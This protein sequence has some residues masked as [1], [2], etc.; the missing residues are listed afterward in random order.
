MKLQNKSGSLDII[1]DPVDQFWISRNSFYIDSKGKNLITS[2]VYHKRWELLTLIAGTYWDKKIKLSCANND[3]RRESISY[4]INHAKVNTKANRDGVF[5]SGIE[6]QDQFVAVC[7]E[8][9]RKPIKTVFSDF[10]SAV[11]CYS[12]YSLSLFYQILEVPKRVPRKLKKLKNKIRF[13]IDKSIV[14]L[15]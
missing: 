15:L 3:L 8:W 13:K 12:R 10:H 4:S 7:G 14:K 1:V 5:Y 2:G 9:N 11:D 6:G